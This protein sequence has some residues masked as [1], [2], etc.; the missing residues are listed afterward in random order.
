ME[1]ARTGLLDVA[2]AADLGLDG[3]LQGLVARMAAHL[4]GGGLARAAA[5]AEAVRL[6]AVAVELRRRLLLAALGA[7]LQPDRDPVSGPYCPS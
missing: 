2:A 4:A 3:G 6:V 1:G 5:A 7:L